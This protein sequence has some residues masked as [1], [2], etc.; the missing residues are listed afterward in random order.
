MG[1][2]RF[3]RKRRGCIAP[4]AGGPIFR[5]LAQRYDRP[6]HDEANSAPSRQLPLVRQDELSGLRAETQRDADPAAWRMG[7]ASVAAA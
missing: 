3:A 4:V 2:S 7:C 6:M 5:S 1:A